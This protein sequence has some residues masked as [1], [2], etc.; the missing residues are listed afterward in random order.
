M[1]APAQSIFDLA[2]RS[3]GAG[4]FV[5]SVVMVIASIFMYSAVAAFDWHL[6]AET[7]PTAPPAA[8]QVFIDNCAA[9]HGEDGRGVK[10]QGA[11]LATSTFV[12]TASDAALVDF[13]KTGRQPDAPDST[14]KLLMPAF[15]Y[16]TEEEIAQ[17]IA[18]IRGLK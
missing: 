10:D 9:C 14:M 2:K 13:L 17:T 1:P 7:I 5:F 8:K 18:F 15:D 3:R 4:A 16:M 12:K 6:A 11:N